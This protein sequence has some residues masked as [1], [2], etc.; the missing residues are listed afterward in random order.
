MS[1]LSIYFEPLHEDPVVDAA[2]HRG[3]VSMN[4]PD[5]LVLFDKAAKESTKSDIISSLR[6]ETIS[7]P[8]IDSSVEAHLIRSG[9]MTF[10]ALIELFMDKAYDGVP[11]KTDISGE[12][13]R[14]KTE[15]AQIEMR[16]LVLVG[17]IITQPLLP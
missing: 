8:N 10:P 11:V 17:P 3:F 4:S 15:S 16:H 6:G 7:Q 1:K 5:I 2:T 9:E 12:F 13:R 14:L